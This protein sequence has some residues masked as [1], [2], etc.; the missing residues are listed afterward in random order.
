MT[1]TTSSTWCRCNGIRSPAAHRSSRKDK[2]A[3][4]P[5]LPGSTA[6]RHVAW[7]DGRRDHRPSV[8]AR[9]FARCPRTH[10]V[11]A[12]TSTLV[13]AQTT[14][15]LGMAPF[16]WLGTGAR[17][18]VTEAE[19]YRLVRAL[20]DRR[21]RGERAASQHR[22]PAG[23]LR[24]QRVLE[25]PGR[26]EP[27]CSDGPQRPHRARP[28]PVRASDPGVARRR[29]LVTDVGDAAELRPHARRARIER[30]R[31][32]PPR[33]GAHASQRPRALRRRLGADARDRRRAP[34][35]PGLGGVRGP[36]G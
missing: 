14:F 7:V 28:R 31:R 3:T 15:E 9:F 2:S 30:R 35:S 11:G 27:G 34:G 8:P 25:Q 21:G 1:T 32:R 20:R 29:R 6:R 10:L 12:S 4:A 19:L 17:D 5:P 33:C 18:L 22:S 16:A 24:R 26:G 13:S 36:R 23:G